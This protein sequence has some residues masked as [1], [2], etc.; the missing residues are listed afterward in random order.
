MVI[1]GLFGARWRPVMLDPFTAWTRLMSAAFDLGRT[2]QNAS[3]TIAAS[4]DV[5]ARRTDIVAAAMR[6]PMTGDYAELARMV[7]EKVEAFSKGG[8][9]MAGEWWS[10]QAAFM[11]EAQHLGGL[12]MRGRPPSVAEFSEL[13]SRTMSYAVHSVERAAR[14]GSLG[15]SPVHAAATANARRLRRREHK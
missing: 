2:G 4:Q 15:L 10:M 11:A 14:F 6:S 1:S 13:S 5:I 8:V 7:P 3:A 12:M 9:A